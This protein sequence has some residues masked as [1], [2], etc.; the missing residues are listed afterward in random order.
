M[1]QNKMVRQLL[2]GKVVGLILALT[3]TAIMAT[4]MARPRAGL[5]DPAVSTGCDQQA[6]QVGQMLG[7]NASDLCPGNVPGAGN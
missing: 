7:V 1:Y 6:Q 3:L 2:L 4:S 5:G